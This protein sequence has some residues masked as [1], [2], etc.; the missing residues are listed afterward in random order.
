M[1]LLA[2]LKPYNVKK[3]HLTRIYMI[4][5][6]RFYE[7]RGWY[8]VPD[9]L[10]EKLRVLHQDH[11]DDDSPDLFDVCTA[12]EAEALEARELKAV[13]VKA[14]AKKALKISD[15]TL[16]ERV[17]ALTS[18]EPDESGDLT[19]AELK[20]APAAMIDPADDDDDKAADEDEGR[21]VEVGRVTPPAHA[22]KSLPPKPRTRR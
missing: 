22:G 19:S 8:E 9:D 7:D 3:G 2:R 13:E 20:P 11:Y 15:S 5:G 12:D 18:R 1:A 14:T 4:D 21:A 6:A 16:R 10:G 17:R